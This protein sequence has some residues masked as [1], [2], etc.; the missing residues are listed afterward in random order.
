M[1]IPNP[2]GIWVPPR[3]RP[4]AQPRIITQVEARQLQ[5][6]RRTQAHLEAIR[7]SIRDRLLHG[8]AV[9]N[10]PLRVWVESAEIR[11][12]THTFLETAYGPAFVAQ[13]RQAV[14][15]RTQYRVMIAERAAP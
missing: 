10:G 11:A 6:L 15:P 4:I 8:A 12:I 3:L 14:P 1:A 2:E 5:E 9:E 7:H 13:L